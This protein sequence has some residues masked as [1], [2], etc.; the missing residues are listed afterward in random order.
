MDEAIPI[1]NM[2]SEEEDDETSEWFL[3]LL[4][5]QLHAAPYHVLAVENVSSRG[6]SSSYVLNLC[7]HGWVQHVPILH[8]KSAYLIEPVFLAP[9]CSINYRNVQ[10]LYI[11]THVLGPSSSYVLNLCMHGWVQH[12][13]M[14]IH[15][16]WREHCTCYSRRY[17][18]SEAHG[19]LRIYIIA[20][21]GF[22]S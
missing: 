20:Q 5:N 13:P 16:R 19:K 18:T 8:L 9:E 22:K 14:F 6:P 3:S 10:C 17:H 21:V 4:F 15:F 1:V 7:M 2:D 11:K 12:V